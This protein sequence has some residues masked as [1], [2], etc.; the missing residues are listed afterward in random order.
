MCAWEFG[1][2]LSLTWVEET[3]CSCLLWHNRGERCESFTFVNLGVNMEFDSLQ[4]EKFVT[5]EMI[6]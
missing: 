5:P 1:L 2:M 3:T 4:L 6:V